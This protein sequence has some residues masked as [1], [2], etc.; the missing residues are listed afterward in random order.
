[1]A[2]NGLEWRIPGVTFNNPN[3]PYDYPDEIMST[4]SLLLIDFNHPDY[5]L[6]AVPA[7]NATIQN[8]AWDIAK[9]IIGSGDEATL[10]AVVGNTL[11]ANEGL[12]EVTP[13]KG[14]HIMVSKTNH[15]LNHA[16][17]IYF[18][19]LVRQYLFDK[20]TTNK[21]YASLWS[22]NTRA[23]TAN[24]GVFFAA[25]SNQPT[26]NFVFNFTWNGVSP[27]SNE[28]NR[29]GARPGDLTTL[30]NQ[31]RNVASS[32]MK[33]AD[34]EY[35]R[36]QT[37]FAVGNASG[38]GSTQQNA[39]PSMILYRLYVEDLTVS[40]RTYEQVDAID[41]AMYDAAFGVGGKFYQDTHSD[42]TASMP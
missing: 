24:T 18:P 42:P 40:G 22:K 17:E 41:K 31:L 8:I 39:A 30:G 33:G 10:R 34:S 21:I 6:A 26:N 23:A 9:S 20:R 32:N 5:T 14:L 4:G 35:T 27:A 36:W 37:R 25:S 11:A 28:S 15:V 29:L 12:L 19:A 3:L 38:F 2:N 7:H 1:M 16:Y 13:K